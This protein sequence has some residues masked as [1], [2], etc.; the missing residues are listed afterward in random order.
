M[1]RAVIAGGDSLEEQR[2]V[3]RNVKSGCKDTPPPAELDPTSLAATL[4][5]NLTPHS[6]FSNFCVQQAAVAIAF[7]PRVF[8]FN[9]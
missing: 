9:S 3:M 1:T 7:A 8:L 2:G 6:L 5:Q 4:T